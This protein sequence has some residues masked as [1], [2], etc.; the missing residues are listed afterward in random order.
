[1]KY[2]IKIKKQTQ[3]QNYRKVVLFMIVIFGL[4]FIRIIYTAKIATIGEQVRQI[5]HQRSTL[6][7]DIN[8]LNSEIAQMSSLN[9]IEKRATE[10][11]KMIKNNSRIA[12]LNLWQ[13]SSILAKN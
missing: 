6:T 3:T 11:L 2:K 13:I 8:L 4:Y 5:E 9:V 1:M 10:D 7:Q 12:Y